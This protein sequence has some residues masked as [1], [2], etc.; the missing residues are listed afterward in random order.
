[1]EDFTFGHRLF[2]IDRRKTERDLL[3]RG[4]EPAVHVTRIATGTRVQIVGRFADGWATGLALGLAHADVSLQRGF[5]RRSADGRCIADLELRPPT[6]VDLRTFP[7]LAL[8]TR[9]PPEVP[10]FPVLLET[11]YIDGSPDAGG[12]LYLEVRGLDA[13]GFLGSL[14]QRLASVSLFPEEMT[15]ETRARNAVDS[16]LLRGPEGQVPGDDAE[17]AL[18]D[19][20]GD[21]LDSPLES[22]PTRQG[23]H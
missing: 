7:F 18:A 12:S 13:V 5:A 16:F 17:Q 10:S 19:I 15:L 6:S 4:Q 14:L 9:Q 2:D 8:A 11:F 22:L 23:S 1:M 21:L 3:S 20:L